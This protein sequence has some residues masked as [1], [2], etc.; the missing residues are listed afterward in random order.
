MSLRK[1]FAFLFFTSLFSGCNK[2][3]DSDLATR[4][5][6][7]SLEFSED[8]AFA[9]DFFQEGG[10]PTENWWEM[11]EDPQLNRLIE[12]A[13][14]ESPTLQRAFAKVEEVEQAAKKER[15]ALFPY[16][17]ANYQE[18][19]DY[20][21]KNGF[22]RS[23]FPT[24]PGMPIP[25]TV[26]ELD[27]TLNFTYEFDFFGRNR[28][29]FQAALGE[30]RAQRADA[31]MAKLMLT[32]L[33]TQSYIDLQMKL[34]QRKIIQERIE[35]KREVYTLTSARGAHGIDPQIPVLE[36]EQTLYQSDQSLIQ[37]D[38]EIAL[39][40]HALNRLVG[41]GPDEDL[42]LEQMSALFTH[43]FALPSELSTDLLARRPDLAAHI[44]RVEAAAQAIGAAK[45]DFY[46]R[47][48]LVA[49]AGLEGLAFNQL[50]Q[51]S[52]KQG[53]LEPAIHLPIFLGGKLK[54]NLREKVAL[55]NEAVHAYNESLLRAA[56]E[57]A[58]QITTL[59]STYEL[60]ES[61][62]NTVETA[63]DQLLLQYSRYKNAL[64]NFI[65]VLKKQDQ[66]LDEHYLLLGYERDYLLSVVKLVKSLGG[67]Y[68][69]RKSP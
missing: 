69:M 52:S 65:E 5:E 61:Q 62:W 16:L 28:K 10:W 46:P 59:V 1:F 56:S 25:A 19:W 60:L 35:Q 45:A 31:Q 57:V 66:Y 38:K 8:Y 15:A 54:A 32:T 41:V 37:I 44:W 9:H 58:D 33:I 67:G 18:D 50:F 26:N 21:S 2:V 63:E 29:R 23:F 3:P 39:D 4:F 11:F 30:A 42:L 53:G 49:F 17:T 64:V 22:I 51:I 6:P 40:R 47:V 14:V 48:N 24:A 55:F 20:F 7:V 27:L 13:L 36:K 43:S 12:R 68:R 34:S